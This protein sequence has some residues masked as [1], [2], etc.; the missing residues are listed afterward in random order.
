MKKVFFNDNFF[1][2]K[3]CD[4][5]FIFLF[6]LE[7]NSHPCAQP[8][9]KLGTDQVGC[10]AEIPRWYHDHTT[11]ECKTFNYD[12]CN[13][14]ENHFETKEDCDKTCGE[15]HK[16]HKDHH[17]GHNHEN[18]EQHGDCKD[19]KHEEHKHEEHEGHEHAHNHHH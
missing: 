16:E 7:H 18:H 1:G 8:L 9:F 17:H 14:N 19:H 12:G 15:W 3:I 5:S 11:G 10:F 4:F 13:K 2:F 6:F